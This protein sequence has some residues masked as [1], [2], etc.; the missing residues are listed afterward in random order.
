MHTSLLKGYWFRMTITVAERLTAHVGGG[1]GPEGQSP[2]V[3]AGGGVGRVWGES[4][5]MRPEGGRARGP[6]GKR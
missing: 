5:P 6:S 1:T 2:G 4:E 3:R